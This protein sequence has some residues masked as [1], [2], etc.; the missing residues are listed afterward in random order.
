MVHVVRDITQ[1]KNAEGEHRQLQSQL[2]QAQKMEAVGRLAGGIAHDFNNILSAILGYSELA[3]MRLQPDDKLHQQLSII[4]ESGQKAAGLIRRLLTFSRTQPMERQTVDPKAVVESIGRMLL[5]LI[6]ED[7]LLEFGNCTSTR[8]VAADAG[9]LEQVLMNLAVNARDAMPTG[10]RLVIQ[11]VDCDVDEAFA[12]T[13]PTLTPGAYVMLSVSD[14]GTGMPPEVQERIFEPF[15]ST[16]EKGKGTGLGLATVYGIIQQH[17]GHIFVDSQPGG[18]TIF[19]IFLP[20]GRAEAK[21]PALAAEG[22][23]P[24]GSETVLVVEDDPGLRK[25]VTDILISLGYRVIT[26][27]G[28]E[29]ALTVGSE[30]ESPIHLL[31]TDVVMPELSG[32]QVAEALRARRPEIQVLF[33]SGHGNE[34]I[35]AHGMND[36]RA[37]FIQKPFTPT[38]LATQV[39]AALDQSLLPA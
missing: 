6:G 16:K 39:R 8:T 20:A 7:I 10:G 33:M 13:Y 14:T 15:F 38:E 4:R 32:R 34:A 25:L 37:H 18:G 31:L 28:A 21:A 17:E 36:G 30:L 9:Q 5:R 3:L 19:R 35:E 27:S 11:T 22:P 24:G 23:T 1:N 12:G 29:E 2:I 26:T